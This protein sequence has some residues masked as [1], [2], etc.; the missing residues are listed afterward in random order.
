MRNWIRRGLC[1]VLLVVFVTSGW[2]VYRISREYADASKRY[3]ELEQYVSVPAR[4]EAEP[5][6]PGTAE[7]PPVPAETDT[8]PE[9]DFET[10]SQINPDLVGWLY[11]EGTRINYP[12]VQ[13][14]D[15]GKYLTHQFDGSRNSSGC[16]FLDAENDPFFGEK[17]HIVYGHYMKN[18][19][20]F[21]DLG[22]YKQQEFYDEHPTGW[23]M[24]PSG[25]YRIRFF[26]GY[27]ANTGADAWDTAFSDEAYG[28][29]LKTLGKK[30]CFAS[31][32]VPETGDRILT[33]STCSYEFD[34]ARFVV[35]GILEEPATIAPV[36]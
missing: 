27:V 15:N 9:V 22:G 23:L 2:K 16:L 29:W 17:N 10:L 7:E 13:G 21:Y 20:M 30:S 32:V 6:P 1:A 25:G 19:S 33:L 8:G 18:K 36:P 28:A 34:D 3:T 24:T 11:V 14:A 5:V 4:P 12:V 31:G 26:S 35:H